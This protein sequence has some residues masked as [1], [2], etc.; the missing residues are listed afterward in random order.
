MKYKEFIANAAIQIMAVQCESID[1]SKFTKELENG[2]I[3]G[4]NDRLKEAASNAV[5]AAKALADELEDDFGYQNKD[6][7]SYHK[8]SDFEN[9]FDDYYTTK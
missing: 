5:I 8:M 9:F 1:R 7:E 6:L 4:P 3:A 2:T